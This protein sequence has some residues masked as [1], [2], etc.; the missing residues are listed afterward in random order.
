MDNRLAVATQKW[1]E[2]LVEERGDEFGPDTRA[3][4][5]TARVQDYCETV[6]D[7]LE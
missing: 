3:S 7:L 5:T 4:L 2:K 1:V 6:I